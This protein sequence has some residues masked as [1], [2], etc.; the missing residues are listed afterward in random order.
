LHLLFVKLRD[1]WAVSFT[2]KWMIRI[3]Y[4]FTDESQRHRSSSKRVPSSLKRFLLKSSANLFAYRIETTT[5]KPG[6]YGVYLGEFESPLTSAQIQLLAEW[7]LLIVDPSQAGVAEAISSGL[8]AVSPQVLARLDVE[9]VASRSSEH[10]I[11]SITQWVTRLIKLS[12]KMTGHQSRFSG[13]VIS[14]WEDHLTPGLAKEFIIFSSSLG[15]SIYLETSQPRF[16]SEPRLAEMNEVT[17]LVI[18]NGTISFS[19]EERDAFQMVEMRP[20]IK[21]FV[22][23]ACLR[24]FVVLLWET[25]D[26]NASPLN[27]V[28][29]RSYQWSRFYSALP[30]IGKTSALKS[31]ELAIQQS[32]P[33]GAFD[34]LKELRVMEIHDRWRSSQSVSISTST[35]IRGLTSLQRLNQLDTIAPLSRKR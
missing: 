13:L 2:P 16:L 20:T 15:L 6:S 4:R 18:R 33:L 32:E 26:E 30:W 27:A 21:A 22:S 14:H 8:H 5:K 11:V 35:I 28:V 10:P 25:L 24:T 34:W 29:K 7:D 31:A 9:Y 1:S 23:Q 19:G 17:G 3:L 12:A